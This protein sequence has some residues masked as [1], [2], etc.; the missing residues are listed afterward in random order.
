MASKKASRE[1]LVLGVGPLPHEAGERLHAPGLRLDFFARRI[2]EAGHNVTVGRALFDEAAGGDKALASQ[3]SRQAARESGKGLPFSVRRASPDDPELLRLWQ[4]E[5]GF[6][7]IIALTDPMARLAVEARLP[8]PLVVDYYGDPIAERQMQG[9]RAGSDDALF[10]GFQAVLPALLGA[11]G[12]SACCD[13]QRHAILGQLGLVGRLNRFS[14]GQERV[15]IVRPAWDFGFPESEAEANASP[16]V[17]GGRAPQDATLLLWAGGYNNWTDVETLFAAVEKAMERVPELRF[18]SAGGE[19]PGHGQ[20]VY[21]KLLEKIAA[22]PNADRWLMLGWMKP[23]DMPR[24]YGECDLAINLDAPCAEGEFGSRSRLLDWARFGPAILTTPLCELADRL[25]QAGGAK[26]FPISD[27]DALAEAIVSLAQDRDARESLK[28]QA[29]AFLEKWR[30]EAFPD[31]LRAW[32]ADPQPAPDLP[33]PAE[34]KGFPGLIRPRN[35]LADLMADLPASDWL[36][37]W[38]RDRGSRLYQ[39]YRKTRGAL[40]KLRRRG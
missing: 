23:R 11:D 2:A 8:A 31:S 10:H 26:A 39:F 22:S 34:R 36:G 32:I 35:P 7:A 13:A 24:L 14:A 38:R 9:L 21:A 3:Y 33:P 27:V 1:V 28:K 15:H 29:A 20:G 30:A 40:G 12:F 18:V 4:M 17:R 6:D 5:V 16:L 25:A 19:I 37:E